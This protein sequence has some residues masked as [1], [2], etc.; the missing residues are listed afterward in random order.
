MKIVAGHTARKRFGQNFLT[1]PR[2][3]HLIAD[4]K[5]KP[6]GLNKF[7]KAHDEFI[8]VLELNPGT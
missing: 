6:D 2:A 4:K 5:T 3:A 8:K 7:R 1:D